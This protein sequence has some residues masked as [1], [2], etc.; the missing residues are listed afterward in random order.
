MSNPKHPA[1]QS[2]AQAVT[3]HGVGS[4]FGLMGDANLFMVDHYVKGCGGTFVPA[5]HEGGAVLMALAHTHVS[6]RMG[7]ATITHGPAL[8][9]CS[10]A[11]TEGTRGRIPMVLLAGDTAVS[12]PENLQNIDQREVVKATGAG[13]EQVR[14]P[15]TAAEDIARAFH[16]AARDRRPVVANMPADFMWME[17]EHVKTVHPVFAAPNVVQEG[18]HLDEAIGMIASSRR[19]IVLAGH[20]AIDA[21]EQV[22]ALADRLEA[23]LAT[24]LRAKGLFNGHPHTM[25]VFGTVSSPTAYDLISKGDCIVCL[26]ASLHFF[27][28]DRGKLIEGK[29]V[30]LVNADGAEIGRNFHPDVALQADAGLAAEKIAWWLDQAEIPPSG[31]TKELEGVKLVDHPPGNPGKSKGG[32]VNYEYAL[33][34]LEEALPGDRILVTDGGRFMTEVWCRLTVRDPRSFIP[35]VPF[36][37]I[38]LGLQHAVGA[39]VAAP[40]RPVALFTGDGGFM[41]GGLTEFNTAVRM[42]LDL[43]VVVANDAAYGAEYIQ[44]QDRQ[45]D[46]GLSRFGWPSFAEAAKALGGDGVTVDSNDSLEAALDAI[47][48]GA[49]PLLIDLKLDPDTVP[50]MRT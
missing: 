33:D 18:D 36:G 25:G 3:D 34:R 30:I 45:M 5:A 13:F 29:R 44:F 19:P 38:G 27:T 39:G 6:G 43:T 8:T 31:F 46:P 9:N 23:P 14:S 42:G 22:I 21:R 32:A 49:G 16:R 11:L 41:M 2:I 35:T 26:G 47:G 20:G 4:M 1:F 17:V 50:R 10:T 12:N 37:S 7:V 28:T 48:A 24:T 15:E 40:G